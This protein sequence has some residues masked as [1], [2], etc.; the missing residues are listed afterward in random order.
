MKQITELLSALS[1]L[2]LVMLLIATCVLIAAAVFRPPEWLRELITTWRESKR[3]VKRLK[4]GAL[5]AEFEDQ[6]VTSSLG[7]PAQTEP[8]DVSD[9]ESKPATKAAD[10]TPDDR[11]WSGV[12]ILY[13]GKYT[14][15]MAAVRETL[16]GETDQRKVAMRLALAQHVGFRAGATQALTDL[17]STASN[18]PRVAKARA[19]LAEA[20]AESGQLDDACRE[21]HEAIT[22]AVDA[23]ERADINTRL[24]ALLA[25]HDRPAEARDLLFSELL[26]TS[27][28]LAKAKLAIAAA[29]LFDG[30]SSVAH[31]HVLALHE[32]AVSSTPNDR[33]LLFDVAY[34]ASKNDAN[35]TAYLMYQDLVARQPDNKGA[36][37]N[38]GVAADR[39]DMSASAVRAYRTAESLDHSLAMANLAQSLLNA[40]FVEDASALLDRARTKKAVDDH[41]LKVTGSLAAVREEDT[42]R[43]KELRERGKVLH[44]WRLRHAQALL[45]RLQL[46]SLIGVYAGSDGLT[47]SIESAS[48]IAIS[49]WFQLDGTKTASFTGHIEGQL[50]LLAWKTNPAK[51]P[52]WHSIDAGRGLLVAGDSDTLTGYRLPADK[53]LDVDDVAQWSEW[54]LRRV[55]STA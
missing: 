47:L 1:G 14:E 41:V 42:K 27:E 11:F 40:G 12:G 3:T 23:S 43:N 39:L 26:N 33:G 13:Q 19:W 28:P 8:S 9:D 6:V 54:N 31:D 2:L 20:L 38:L 16:S 45:G 34:A 53:V 48:A 5:E 7:T 51:A 24:A 18:N 35:G 25:K 10:A 36:W 29:K 50:L 4:A 21:L 46:D 17:R 37:N 49:G 30:E 22:V 32:L 55:Q 52:A 44:K 15:G